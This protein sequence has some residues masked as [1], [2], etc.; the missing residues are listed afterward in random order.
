MG[1]IQGLSNTGLSSWHDTAHQEP[2][3]R[4]Q[5]FGGVPEADGDLDTTKPKGKT[6]K[7]KAK[8]K[9]KAKAKGKS[10][11]SKP[12]PKAKAKAKAKAFAK[13]KA[14]KEKVEESEVLVTPKRAPPK[15]D[16][17]E[18][19]SRSKPSKKRTSEGGTTSK[20]DAKEAPTK[21]RASKGNAAS[22]ARR[23]PPANE[24]AKAE[25]E[26]IRSAYRREL[27]YLRPQTKPEDRVR[28]KDL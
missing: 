18:G 28:N 24:R 15:G 8:S 7:A 25:W 11:S 22:F 14:K 21:T 3:S 20:K 6:P 16:A 26:A 12:S 17:Q 9:A 27:M 1:S 19:G 5:Q 2:L 13:S 4:I 10:R 23:N